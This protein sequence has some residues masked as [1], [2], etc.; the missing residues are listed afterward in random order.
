MSTEVVGD[1]H[2]V[3]KIMSANTGEAMKTAATA[4]LIEAIL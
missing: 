2:K 3:F 4:L 1:E